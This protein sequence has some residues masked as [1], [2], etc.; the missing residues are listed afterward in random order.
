M[1]SKKSKYAINALVYLA[2]KNT[3]DPTPV[4]Q[5][6]EAQ[7][8]P[9]KFLESILLDLKNQGILN[10]RKGPNGGYFLMKHPDEVNLAEVVRLFD[11]AIALLPCVT[12]RFYEKCEECQDEETCGIRDVF[13]EVRRQTVALLKSASLSQIIDR[14]NHLKQFPQQRSDDD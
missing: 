9:H 5:I 13:F 1:L 12:F 3:K 11:G 4:A 6:A 14:E 8:I 7:N 10:S 2:K